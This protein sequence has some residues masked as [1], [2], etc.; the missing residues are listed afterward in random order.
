MSTLTDLQA[1][2]TVGATRQN[3]AEAFIATIATYIEANK[4]T[5][6]TIS[7]YATMLSTNKTILGAAVV[8]THKSGRG[9]WMDG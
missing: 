7:A 2:T 5:A 3:A 8:R 4:A 1:A 9:K 6:A